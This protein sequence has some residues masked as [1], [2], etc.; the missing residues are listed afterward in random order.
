MEKANRPAVAQQFAH[1]TLR[2]S[3]TAVCYRHINIHGYQHKSGIEHR[4]LAAVYTR[5]FRKRQRRANPGDGARVLTVCYSASHAE[6]ALQS[7]TPAGEATN[8][9]DDFADKLE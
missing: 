9:P 1:P 4:T 5:I 6:L 2:H 7:S 8:S 3:P